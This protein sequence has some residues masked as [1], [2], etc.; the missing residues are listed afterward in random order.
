MELEDILVVV[1]MDHVSDEHYVKSQVDERIKAYLA[2]GKAVY[3]LATMEYPP[4]TDIINIEI[5]NETSPW[6][7]EYQVQNL[8]GILE[9]GSI[10][11]VGVTWFFCVDYVGEQLSATINYDCTDLVQEYDLLSRINFKHND[12]P[13]PKPSEAALEKYRATQT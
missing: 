4:R 12:G 7:L 10:E 6:G 8:Q 2:A 11:V 9:K 1:H 3:N 13:L 5:E